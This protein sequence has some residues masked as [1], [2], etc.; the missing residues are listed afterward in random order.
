MNIVEPFIRQALERPERPAIVVGQETLSYGA[1]LSTV[2]QLSVNL[3][4]AGIGL[5]DRVAV[6]VKAPAGHI[7]VSLALARVG[8]VSVALS[9]GMGRDTLGLLTREFGVSF[10]IHDRSHEEFALP[11]PEFKGELRLHELLTRKPAGQR[12][13]FVLAAPQDIWRI[14]I[15][16]GTTGHPKG[17]L[18]SHGGAL[19][20]AQLQRLVF[21]TDPGDHLLIAMDASMGFSTMYW[22]RALSAG[23]CAV[24][25]RKCISDEALRAIH[26][27]TVTQMVTSPSTARGMAEIAM[28]PDS[29]YSAPPP[30]LRLM[31]VGGGSVSPRLSQALCEHVCPWL[32]ITY[33]ATETSQI[34]L[35]DPALRALHPKSAGRLV[36]WTEAQAVDDRGAPLAVGSVGALRI[37]TPTLSPGY[38]GMAQTPGEPQPFRDGWFYSKDVGSVTREGLIFL[39]GRADDVLNVSGTKIDPE[40]VE[41]AISEDLTVVECVVV[42]VPGPLEQPMLVA[43]VVASGN[44]DID[45]LKQRCRML[46]PSCVPKLVVRAKK[47]PRNQAGKIMR[48]ELRRN[49]RVHRADSAAPPSETADPGDQKS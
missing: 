28:K 2:G 19:A 35:A 40:Q 6:F 14:L 30:G 13:P 17:I 38:A 5:Q 27:G 1:L 15:S 25:L 42:D 10:I 43:V 33:G 9:A 4:E 45:A 37:R 48:D 36:P 39:S 46:G 44:L 31:I 26:S 12:V 49:L 11:H 16:S 34:A 29:P 32:N 24:L 22:L 20:T 21:P 41:A 18:S 23:A 7:G 3:L 8:A 47:L